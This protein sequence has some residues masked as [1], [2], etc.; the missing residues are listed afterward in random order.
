MKVFRS[1]RLELRALVTT[2]LVRALQSN[3]SAGHRI[4]AVLDFFPPSGILENGK[5]DVSE[6]GSVSVLR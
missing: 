4:T 3:L 1:A 6:I 5:H 2:V